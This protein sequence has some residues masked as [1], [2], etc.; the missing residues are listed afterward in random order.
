MPTVAEVIVEHLAA[1][2]VRTVFGL[3]GGE[4]VE[5]LDAMRR[6]EMRFVLV[7]NESSALFMADAYNRMTGEPGVCLTTLGPGATNAVM[8]MAHAYLDRSPILLITAQKPDPLLPDYTH[9]VV[10]LQAI[11]DPISK[12]TYKVSPGNV[13]HIMQTSLAQIFADRPGPV[14]LQVSNEVAVQAAPVAPRRTLADSSAT[15][16][17]PVE[18]VRHASELLASAKKPILV[19]GLGLEPEAPY[20]ALLALA[21]SLQAPVIVTPKAKGAN[22]EDHPLFAGTIGLN[23]ADPAYEVLDE[24]DCV[25]AFAFDVVELVRPWK[26]DA[27][28][29]WVAPWV[30]QDPV[31]PSLVEFVG[32][33]TPVL[34]QLADAVYDPTPAWG[35][36]RVA[37]FRKSP[38]VGNLPE[39]APGRILP[40]TVLSTLQSLLPPETFLSVDVGSHKIHSSLEWPAQSPN[41]FHLSN[42]LSSMSFSLP[43]AMGAALAQA[44]RHAVALTGDAG[45]N[46]ILGELSVLVAE[47]LPVICIVLNDGAID[48]IR[49]HQ[50]RSGK[51][52]FGTEFSAPNYAQ[53]AQAFG[54]PGERVQN[55]QELHSAL[56][57]ALQRSGP[58]LIEVMLDPISYP[59]TPGR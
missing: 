16:T 17:L 15:P 37:A 28:L 10:D 27:P 33:M 23:R 2:G 31:M 40:H 21:E 56:T 32:P 58:T 6:T 46:M 22:P 52:V 3:P 57:N 35:Q 11:F 42:G 45:M 51:P 9:Q 5:I 29:I 19:L 39:A 24:A 36:A 47:Q 44:D 25:L 59:T 53:I 7:H 54:L 20:T 34:E 8:G 43:A 48:L 26:H 30:N 13:H 55:P 14:H 12:A 18:S 4:T 41:R 49:S 1:A 50:V 38:G